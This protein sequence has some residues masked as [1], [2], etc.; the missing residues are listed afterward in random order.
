MTKINPSHTANLTKQLVVKPPQARI[1]KLIKAGVTLAVLLAA[2]WAGLVLWIHLVPLGGL[3]V[4]ILLV[5]GV[6]VGLTLKSYWQQALHWQKQLALLWTLWLML[7]MWFVWLPPKQD[8]H[9]M[10]EVSQVLQ[11]TQDPQNPNLITLHNV[12]NFDWVR[13]TGTQPLSQ[14]EA[15]YYYKVASD[16]TKEVVATERWSER[17]VDLDKLS[18]VDIVN[19]YWMGEQIAHTLLS[20]RFEDERPLS[21]SIE[22]RKE[23]SESFS[24]FGGFVKQ[25]EMAVVAAEERDIIYTRTNVRGEQVYLLPIEGMSK[26]Q[27]QALFKAYLQQVKQLQQQP[28]WYNTLIRNCTTVIFDM[29]RAIDGRDFPWDYRIL[30]SGYVPNYL[31]DQHLLPRQ[32]QNWRIEQWYKAAHINP[33]VAHFSVENNQSADSYSKQIRQQIPQPALVAKAD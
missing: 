29:A 18:G 8:R 6:G 33:K 10:P 19:S 23:E 13:S 14:P 26:A 2:L 5:L 4:I 24:A 27:M 1:S 21:F 15:P 3:R 16:D 30:M 31:Y 20:F 12:R 25:F 9:W 22:I 7:L 28:I 17:T 32:T 11:F